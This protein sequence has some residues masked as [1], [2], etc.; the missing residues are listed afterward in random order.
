MKTYRLQSGFNLIELI[1][2]VTIIGVLASIAIPAYQNYI[3]RTKISDSLSL[4]RNA[5]MTVIENASNGFAFES[6]WTPPAPTGTVAS[7]AIDVARGRGEIIITYTAKIAP[8]GANTLVL[9][10]RIAGTQARLRL[11]VIP[12][13]SIV[14]N[15]NSADQ[16]QATHS[17]AFGTIKGVY[18]PPIC[19]Q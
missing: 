12:E 14:W 2:V 15:C 17:G 19:R 13:G 7:V 6:G 8:V 3:I 4:A 10:P 16:N 11:G 9:A 5:Q 18:T 1:I